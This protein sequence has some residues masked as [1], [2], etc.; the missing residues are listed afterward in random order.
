MRVKPSSNL[1]TRVPMT[2]RHFREKT[3]KYRRLAKSSLT[4][5]HM[6]TYVAMSSNI[7]YIW[8]QRRVLDCLPYD[9]FVRTG[10]TSEVCASS[11][12]GF[13][14]SSP[15]YSVYETTTQ[16]ISVCDSALIKARM[17]HGRLLRLLS[18]GVPCA[19]PRVILLSKLFF[20]Q[21]NRSSGGL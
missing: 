19:R 4:H 21:T 16:F 7:W 13:V 20:C 15:A 8:C 2:R 3:R 17:T 10:G 14:S 18:F 9:A 5:G 6:G 11:V 12:G 1:A